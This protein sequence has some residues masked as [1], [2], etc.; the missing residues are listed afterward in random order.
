MR[1][2]RRPGQ[3]RTR[4]APA[5]AVRIKAAVNAVAGA[6]A[7]EPTWIGCML[8]ITPVAEPGEIPRIA[9]LDVFDAAGG[10]S[11]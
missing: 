1:V 10:G 11:G 3:I 8:A 5:A 6:P 9:Q 4:P 2:W 7:T